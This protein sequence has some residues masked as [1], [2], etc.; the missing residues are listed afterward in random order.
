MTLI[1]AT[2]F[3]SLG[4][5]F[6]LPTASRADGLG[7]LPRVGDC[8]ERGGDACCDGRT[9]DP[10]LAEGSL[11]GAVPLNTGAFSPSL[12]RFVTTVPDDKKDEAGGYQKASARLRFVDSRNLL[13]PQEWWC[14]VDVGMP[15]RT[16]HAGRISP[17]YA[18]QITADVATEATPRVMQRQSQWMPVA[19]CIQFGVEM[20]KLFGEHYSTVGATAK[21]K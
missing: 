18:A 17:E 2:L 16:E 20:R 19:F 12:F 6:A 21:A 11:P 8:R 1:K 9:G 5:L 15:L 3:V 10:D 7:A 13:L 4:L 14:Q